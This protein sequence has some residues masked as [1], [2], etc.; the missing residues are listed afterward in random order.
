MGRK[1][2][3]NKDEKRG[4]K[5][6]LIHNFPHRKLTGKKKG[7]TRKKVENQFLISSIIPRTREENSGSVAIAAS[8]FRN[9]AMIVV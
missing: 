7:Y 4:K 3:K 5:A 2:E 1:V 8:T 9:A 6:K